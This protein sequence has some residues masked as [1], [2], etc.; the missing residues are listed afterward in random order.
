MPI[1]HDAAV[2]ATPD[3]VRSRPAITPSLLEILACP[4]CHGELALDGE[5]LR[6]RPCRRAFRIEDGIPILLLE[7]SRTY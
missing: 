5:E 2:A 1:G 7:E 4:A 3:E 6:C